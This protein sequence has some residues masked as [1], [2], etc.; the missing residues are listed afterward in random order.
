MVLGQRDVFTAGKREILIPRGPN[1][2]LDA[3]KIANLAIIRTGR[4]DGI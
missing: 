2:S 4:E 3:L 1:A